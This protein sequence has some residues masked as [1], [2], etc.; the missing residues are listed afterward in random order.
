MKVMKF[1]PD[2]YVLDGN[3]RD[4]S[5]TAN[6]PIDNITLLYELSGL[7]V[8]IETHKD[9]GVLIIRGDW[10]FVES[11]VGGMSINITLDSNLTEFE[12]NIVLAV[13][14][15]GKGACLTIQQLPL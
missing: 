2:F 6:I 12:R 11:K 13:D 7:T 5:I 1:K 3:K 4:L 15:M 10:F 9:S 14:N 8:P